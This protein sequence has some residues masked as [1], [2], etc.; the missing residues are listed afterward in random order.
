MKLF[1]FINLTNLYIHQIERPFFF[2][3]FSQMSCYPICLSSLLFL[4]SLLSCTYL[5]HSSF[6]I[7]LIR[8]IH[9]LINVLPLATMNVNNYVQ[10]Q[11]GRQEGFMP[12]SK[13]NVKK[14]EQLRGSLS[15]G[16]ALTPK[17]PGCSDFMI[18]IESNI[19]MTQYYQQPGRESI[20]QLF[21]HLKY[22][23]QR[24]SESRSDVKITSHASPLIDVRG[25]CNELS[26]YQVGLSHSQ[27]ISNSIREDIVGERANQSRHQFSERAQNYRINDQYLKAKEPY[28]HVQRNGTLHH[29]VQQIHHEEPLLDHSYTCQGPTTVSLDDRQPQCY[30]LHDRENHHH[31]HL[32]TAPS[33]AIACRPPI[34]EKLFPD[35]SSETILNLVKNRSMADKHKPLQSKVLE[36]LLNDDSNSSDSPKQAFRTQGHCFSLPKKQG[37][38]SL[39]EIQERLP[40]K[41]AQTQK[42]LN[43]F[44]NQ[45]GDPQVNKPHILRTNEI[46]ESKENPDLDLVCK[47]TLKSLSK[48]ISRT[49]RQ[50][51]VIKTI[52][53]I[54]RQLYKKK[55][56]EVLGKRMKNKPRPEIISSL[57][58]MTEILL[59]RGVI[60]CPD[61]SISKDQLANHM[62]ALIM[63]KALQ[64]QMP[65]EN[66]KRN[67]KQSEKKARALST[68]IDSE[69]ASID[70]QGAEENLGG[71]EFMKI[72]EGKQPAS[73]AYRIQKI[74][75][76]ARDTHKVL[77][78]YNKFNL[79]SFFNVKENV[80]IL[81]YFLSLAQ[82]V[83]ATGGPLEKFTVLPPLLSASQRI[84]GATIAQPFREALSTLHAQENNIDAAD[85]NND[86]SQSEVL[87]L[88]QATAFDIEQLTCHHQ[89]DRAVVDENQ[90]SSDS[91]ESDLSH[92]SGDQDPNISAAT[93]KT[94]EAQVEKLINEVALAKARWDDEVP[95]RAGHRPKI[96]DL[97]YIRFT[98]MPPPPQ[99]LNYASPLQQQILRNSKD[100]FP[101]PAPVIPPQQPNLAQAVEIM[102]GSRPASLVERRKMMTGQKRAKPE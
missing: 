95:E 36:N 6:V 64:I 2:H 90:L 72:Q 18:R 61:R 78:K 98:N 7:Q 63:P 54:L 53:R 60:S 51:V 26:N 62:A 84:Q 1:K 44:Q 85:N 24:L 80:V 99:Q 56:D 20:P 70:D 47:V 34:F 50:D 57:D 52:F 21:K 3:K 59:Q 19:Q 58:K 12:F 86:Q 46:E 41:A 75:K 40:L 65:K 79:K 25:K 83:L 94:F 89:M 93:L 38:S 35:N 92:P 42:I 91:D 71:I 9:H 48:K 10:S 4:Q 14:H 8:L 76:I 16:G 97:R 82:K 88:Q 102:S 22:F 43:A 68:F 28:R 17:L 29:H 11:S 73:K 32:Q 81:E 39:I 49:E 100:I 37:P 15:G 30:N 96:I 69:V 27:Q 33:A 23:Q 31:D 5:R 55:L 74:F 66:H 101:T 77:Y 13:P 45:D 67:I 87:E